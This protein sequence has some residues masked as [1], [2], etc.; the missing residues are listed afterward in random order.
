MRIVI[1]GGGKIGLSIATQLTREEHDVVLL[2]NNRSV[3]NWASDKLDMMVMYGNGA[4]LEMQREADV[5]HADLLVAAT[6]LDELNILSCI[7]ARKLGCQ[8]TIARVRNAEYTEQLYFLKEELGL[9]M[10]INPEWAAAREIFRLVQFPGFLK[11]DSFAKGRVEIVEILLQEDSPLKGM[12]LM[13]LPK[14]LKLNILVCAVERGGDVYIPD[15][16]FVLESGDSIFVTAPST[17][18]SDLVRR[19][20][21]HGRKSRDALIVGGSRIAQYLTPM[22]AKAGTRVKIIENNEAR[23]MQL[24]ELL[25]EATIINADGSNQMVLLGENIEKMDTVVTL[26]NIDEE[27]LII[28]MY[29]NHIGVPQV[30]TKINR[31]E[32]NDVFT[33]KGI[34]CIISPKLLCAQSVVRYVRAMQNEEGSS[35]VAIHRL[36]NEK[37]D[38]LEFNVTSAT[39]NLGKSLREIQLKPNILF[40]CINRMGRVIIPGGKDTLEEGDTVVIVTPADRVIVDLNDI[41]MPE[42]EQGL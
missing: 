35:V 12:K 27:N 29:S 36:A 31:T 30:I 37:V 25:P 14:K 2:D 33:N 3:V 18:L 8:N 32:Y 39:W 11:R 6:P 23:A 15:G 21:M 1:V 9:S 7:L 41:F 19:L 17:T 42:E 4:A 34:D 16:S 40:A 26:T 13:S 28:S 24:A 5:E 10:V 22:L 38:A 20:G